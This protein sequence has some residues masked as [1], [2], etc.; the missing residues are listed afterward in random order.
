MNHTCTTHFYSPLY[1]SFS[2]SFLSSPICFYNIFISRNYFF[3]QHSNEKKIKKSSIIKMLINVIF[4]RYASPFIF[5]RISIAG[6]IMVV[7]RAWCMWT[8]V[9]DTKAYDQLPHLT[10]LDAI[11]LPHFPWLSGAINA[12]WNNKNY[13]C[14]IVHGHK[15]IMYTAH[16]FPT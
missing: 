10:C 1:F 2:I 13:P 12:K 14:I 8:L 3:A 15:H 5:K 11:P 16:S 4:L 9:F 6:M 7:T